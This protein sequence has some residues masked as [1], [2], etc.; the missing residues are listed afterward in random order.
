MA[1]VFTKDLSETEWIL[2]DNNNI[3]TFSDDDGSR[4]PLYCDIEITGLETIRIFP[5]PD[6]SFYF[7]FKDYLSSLLDDYEDTIDYSTIDTADIQ[8]FIFDYSQVIWNDDID[9]T[10]TFDNDD[11]ETQSWTPFVLLGVE[12]ERE[13]RKGETIKGLDETI[14]SP[15]KKGTANTYHLRYWNG[16]PFDFSY[17][18]GIATNTTTQTIL[19]NTNA[20]ETPD[21]DL[22]YDCNRVVIGNGDTTQTLEDF[23]SFTIGYNNLELTT[24]LFIDLWKHNTEC[25]VYLKWLNNYGGWNYWLFNEQ[26]RQETQSRSKGRINNDNSNIGDN[27]SPYKNLGFEVE[28]RMNVIAEGLTSED[29]NV[30]K[31]ITRSPKVYLFTGIPFSTNDNND[32][33]EITISNKT[34]AERDFKNNVPD[35]NLTLELPKIHTISL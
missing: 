6:Q 22:D 25:G 34:I 17:T 35:V 30:L 12:Q 4:E 1:L 15:L 33:L 5:L 11:T 14:L 29:I 28:D 23:V 7:N 26:H 2:S 20:I 3:I 19:N 16:Y 31:G 32:W 9:L 21:I 18:R 10:V 8:T 27:N 24:G 13:F